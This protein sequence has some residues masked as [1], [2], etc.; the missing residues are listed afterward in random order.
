MYNAFKAAGKTVKYVN[1]IGD[2]I[3]IGDNNVLYY[4]FPDKRDI[5]AKVRLATEEIY[6]RSENKR[7]DPSTQT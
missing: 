4:C 7:S 6:K 1:E 2:M 5:V 3:C